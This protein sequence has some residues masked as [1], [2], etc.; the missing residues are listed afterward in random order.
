M[1]NHCSPEN[2]SKKPWLCSTKGQAGLYPGVLGRGLFCKNCERNRAFGNR[3]CRSKLQNLGIQHDFEEIEIGNGAPVRPGI[4]PWQVI[5]QI[6]LY[7][8]NSNLSEIQC[9][10]W[11]TASLK[12]LRSKQKELCPGQGHI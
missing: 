1:G 8:Q 5:R 7:G 9:L 3:N 11:I 4:K 2:Y 12:V 10:S 6:V